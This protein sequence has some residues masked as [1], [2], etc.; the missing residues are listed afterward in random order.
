MPF[1]WIPFQEY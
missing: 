1:H